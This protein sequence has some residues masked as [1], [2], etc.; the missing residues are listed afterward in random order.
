MKITIYLNEESL[1]GQLCDSVSKAINNLLA[2]I[3][4]LAS[5]RGVEVSVVTS[6]AIFSKQVCAGTGLTMAQL[7]KVDRDL[8]MAFK[9]MLDKGKYW[10]KKSPVQHPDSRYMFK[11]QFVNGTSVAEAR[12]SVD[13]DMD[14]MLV[15]IPSTNYTGKTLAIEKDGIKKDVPNVMTTAEVFDFLVSKGVVLK[16]DR[17]KFLRVD[18]KQ[19]VLADAS[20]F[21]ETSHMVQGRTVYE[22]IGKG[23][24]WYVDNFHKDGSVHLEVFRMSDGLFMGTCDIEDVNKFKAASKKEK[25]KKEPLRF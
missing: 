2:V 16:Y 14:T 23:E 7:S 19:T 1:Q 12:E 11:K 5:N 20:Q 21:A 4:A 17:S 10:D 18:D 3:N 15:S 13:T 9:G 22:R 25:A 8:F 6:S 24:Y